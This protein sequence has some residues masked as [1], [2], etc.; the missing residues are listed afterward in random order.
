MNLFIYIKNKR[1]QKSKFQYEILTFSGIS[2]NVKN[3]HLDILNDHKES[4][5][6][7]MEV[8]MSNL[9]EEGYE[10]HEIINVEYKGACGFDIFTIDSKI[11]ILK[12]KVNE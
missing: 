8:K 9:F 5:M 10:I 4:M 3:H 7:Q 11:V 12:K 2:H 1:I 6:R